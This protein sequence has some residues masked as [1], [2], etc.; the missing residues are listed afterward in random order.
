MVG[1]PLAAE[2]ELDGPIDLGLTLRP[3]RHGRGD[4]TI[5][6]AANGVWRATLTPEGPATAHLRANRLS[7]RVVHVAAWGPG[8]DWAVAHAA[9]LL[10]ASDAVAEFAPTDPLVRRLHRQARG[11]RIT[12]SRAVLEAILPAVIEQKVTGL[13]ARRAY[14]RLLRA[15]GTRAP[16]PGDG[17]LVVPPG[18]A[19]LA[20][21]PYHAFHPLGLERRR[22]DTLRRAAALAGRLE[23]A[24]SLPLDD[25]HRRL[26]A[27]PGIGPWTAAEVA[28][29]ALGD[30]D[31]VSVGDYH[32]P[33]QVGWALA[34][35]R[36][37]DDAR[38]LALLEPYRGHRARVQRL[39]ETA[40]LGPGR[41]G[42][43]MSV[44]SIAHM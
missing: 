27:V 33:R 14:H 15:Y 32:L 22:A 39:I 10:G 34:G 2:I 25:A 1:A 20:G 36:D 26:R 38:M 9:D 37:A 43:R 23:E 44:R 17:M 21:L 6:F 12:R 40:G 24:V 3:L 29:V 35:E 7:D 41:R 19:T 42:P 5:S 11:L 28:R 31:A 13:E 4:L 18:A 8:A 16:G 30:A